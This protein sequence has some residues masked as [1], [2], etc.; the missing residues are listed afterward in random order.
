M[1]LCT[2]ALFNEKLMEELASENGFYSRKSEA[3]RT[4]DFKKWWEIGED[5]S[6]GDTA[7]EILK[8]NKDIIDEWRYWKERKGF[9]YVTGDEKITLKELWSNF[10]ENWQFEETL[11]AGVFDEMAKLCGGLL[12]EWRFKYTY[13]YTHVYEKDSPVDY[14]KTKIQL[15]KEFK[16]IWGDGNVSDDIDDFINDI[17]FEYKSMS[18]AIEGDPNYNDNDEAYQAWIN[19][20]EN[21]NYHSYDS[22]SMRE[23]YDIWVEFVESGMKDPYSGNS[24]GTCGHRRE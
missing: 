6:I 22:Y 7:M 24:C 15:W 10:K 1:S 8:M 14:N 21:A 9:Y 4:R 20:R 5:G 18:D 3:E 19:Y 16:D 23:Q 13:A 12:W 11:A 17:N 2:N